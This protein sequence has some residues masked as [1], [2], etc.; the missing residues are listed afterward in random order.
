MI[1]G[2]KISSSIQDSLKKDITELRI[3]YKKLPK[4]VV[5]LI[6][7]NP[8][9]ISYVKAKERA[10]KKVGIFCHVERLE[11]NILESE[12]IKFID[13]IKAFWR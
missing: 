13:K 2:K 8:A 12:L 9:S 4:L 10:C 6:G 5:I 3:N 7:K 11:E 1:D